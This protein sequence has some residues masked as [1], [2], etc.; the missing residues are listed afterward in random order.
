MS[1]CPLVCA[2]ISETLRFRHVFPSAI[3]HKTT[4]NEKLHGNFFPEGK[5]VLI[6]LSEA[7]MHEKTWGDPHVFRPERFID[8]SGGFVAK[9][10]SFY[11][12]FGDGRR[13]CPGSKYA[14]NNIFLIVTRFLQRTRDINVVGGVT[15]EHMRGD[16]SVF[17]AYD[18]SLYLI[19]IETGPEGRDCS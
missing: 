16:I 15:G 13:S 9:P 17:P 7:L 10:N 12:P 6:Y 1:E 2:F 18:V 19:Q 11:I 4:T 8:E 3:P 5:T 14:F